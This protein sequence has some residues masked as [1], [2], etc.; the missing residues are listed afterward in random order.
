M[1]KPTPTIDQLKALADEAEIEAQAAMRDRR[2]AVT[3]S[4]EALRAAAKARQKY[5]RASGAQGKGDG[6]G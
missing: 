2:A 1:N 6:S 5:L 3:R 4:Q